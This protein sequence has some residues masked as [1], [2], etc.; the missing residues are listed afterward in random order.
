MDDESFGDS[1]P[2]QHKQKTQNNHIIEAE[3]LKMTGM[4]GHMGFG[5]P[6]I[7]GASRGLTGGRLGHPLAQRAGMMALASGGNTGH[8]DGGQLSAPDNDDDDDF[9][10]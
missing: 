9:W 5:L 10:G 7:A 8:E 3:P 4:G 2:G 6:G 1:S